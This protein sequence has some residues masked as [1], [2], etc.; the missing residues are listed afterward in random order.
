MWLLMFSNIKH[1]L[2]RLDFGAFQRRVV[3]CWRQVVWFFMHRSHSDLSVIVDP[4]PC[5]SCWENMLWHVPRDTLLRP[6]S[7]LHSPKKSEKMACKWIHPNLARRSTSQRGTWRNSR[8]SD[9]PQ[10]V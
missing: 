7:F 6:T 9:L 3:L 4:V 1:C 10:E 2:V 8:R 5:S